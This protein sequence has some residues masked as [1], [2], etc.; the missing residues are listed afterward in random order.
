MSVADNIGLRSFDEAPFAR[1]GW[2][3]PAALRAA[4]PRC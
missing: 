1:G 3:R 4:R 2:R